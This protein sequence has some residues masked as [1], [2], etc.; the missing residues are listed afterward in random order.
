[1]KKK[2][3]EPAAIEGMFRAVLSNGTK[4]ESQPPVYGKETAVYEAKEGLRTVCSGAWIERYENG[5]WIIVQ[6]IK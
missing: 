1:M 5:K 3:E 6:M 4:I 2:K